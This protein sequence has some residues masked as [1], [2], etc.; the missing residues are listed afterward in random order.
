M[1]KIFLSLM[2]SA[3][4]VP[5]TS[6]LA[7]SSVQNK[8]KEHQFFQVTC[9]STSYTMQVDPGRRVVIPSSHFKGKSCSMHVEGQD[10][11]YK[12]NDH[13][14]YQIQPNGKVTKTAG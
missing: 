13:N 11:K 4:L 5:A 3:L 8:T 9:P 10:Q 2:A 14:H 7:D 1:K 12:I 6:A